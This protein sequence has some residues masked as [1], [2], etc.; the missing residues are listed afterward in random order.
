MAGKA[1]IPAIERALSDE[2]A[3]ALA[4]IENIQREDLSVIE[5]AAAATLHTEFGESRDCRGRRQQFD[6]GIELAEI[7]SV[8]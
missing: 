1:V 3:I 8:A 2:L 7:E 5:Q 4:L 6:N